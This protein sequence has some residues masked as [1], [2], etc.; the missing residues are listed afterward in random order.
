MTLRTLD[1]GPLNEAGGYIIHG[2]LGGLGMVLK[3][4]I[5]MPPANAGDIKQFG[6]EFLLGPGPVCYLCT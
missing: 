6:G 4:A 3:N 5:K 2:P 1:A